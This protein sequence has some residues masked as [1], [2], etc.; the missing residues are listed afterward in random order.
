M[1][2]TRKIND[3][4]IWVGVN[5]RRVS[6][7][8]GINPLPKGMSY[9]SYLHLDEKTVL[10]DTVDKAVAERFMENVE[11]A[12]NG[13]NL[14]YLVVLHA[15]PDHSATI[16]NI[17]RQY[18][19]V[20]LVLTQKCAEFI[21]QFY[22]L[23]D[24]VKLQI[25]GENDSLNTGSHNFK[26]IMAPM[27]HWPEV[28]VAYDEKSHTLFSADAFGAFGSLNGAIFADEVDFMQDYKDEARRY[29]TNVVGKYGMQVQ[30]LLKKLAPLQIDMICPLHS[31]VWRKDIDQITELYDK[32]SKYEPEEK[33]VIIAYGSIYG[34]TE[35]AVDILAFS[36]RQKGIKTEMFDIS[37][38][39]VSEILS[40]SFKWSHLVF[41]APT[42]N[43]ALFPIM[44][45]V[46]SKVALNNLQNRKVAFV[47]N[48]SWG[49][50]ASKI[51]QQML[52]KCKN[53]EVLGSVNIKSGI[54][55]AD[56]DNINA[57]AQT[58]ADTF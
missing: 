15:E 41:A 29:Y 48:G 35:N 6:L 36:L 22:G 18:P 25:V 27:V 10:F 47:E 23:S 28:M 5:D 46:L 13:R 26:F 21:R 20:T 34:N 30:N 42:F 45:S 1:H 43:T 4:L 58:L 3:N 11:Y 16:S 55:E 49:S 39:S 32:W 57:L 9:C 12:L 54:K 50:T 51:M 56:V 8:E 17:L 7:F 37:T 14:D 52:E 2:C 31:F 33:G 44:E 19:D 53:F 38:T 40:Q 24:D